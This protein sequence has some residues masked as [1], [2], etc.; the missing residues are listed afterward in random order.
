MRLVHVAST[1]LLVCLAACS[2]GGGSGAPSANSPAAG[3]TVELLAGAPAGEGNADGV[4]ATA[5]FRGPGG[6]AID[7]AGNLYVADIGNHTI[8]KITP[9]RE[10]TTFA[11]SPGSS[12]YG[13]GAGAAARFNSPRGVAIDGAGNLYVSDSGN[14][15]VRKIT[16]AGVVTGLAHVFQ[17][18]Y[19]FGPK[20]IAADSVGNVY[21][22]DPTQSVVRLVEPSGRVSTLAGAKGEPGNVDGPGATA[23]FGYPNGVAVDAAGNVFVSDST[24]HTI[25]RITPGGVV[26]TLAG[27]AGVPGNQNGAVTQATFTQPLDMAFDTAGNLYVVDLV[28]DKCCELRR[29]SPAGIVTTWPQ[30]GAMMRTFGPG[31]V[32]AERNGGGIFYSD[33]S[34]VVRRIAPGVDGEDFAGAS[35]A[36]TQLDGV[37]S[38]ARFQDARSAAVDA[39]GNIFVADA[40]L[41]RKITPAGQVTTF[42]A[43]PADAVAVDAANNLYTAYASCVYP[44]MLPTRCT[45]VLRRISPDGTVRELSASSNSDSSGTDIFRPV[46]IAVDAAGNLYIADDW[47]GAIRRLSPAGDLTTFAK[48]PSTLRDIAMDRAGNLL[49]VDGY[50]VMK[51]TSAGTVSLLAGGGPGAVDGQGS[52]AR[53]TAPTGIAVDSEGNAYVADIRDFLVRKVTPSGVVTTIAGTPG[54]QGFHPGSLPG[55]LNLPRRVAISGRNIYLP[56]GSLVAVIRNAP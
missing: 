17:F 51:V 21:V 1:T 43:V 40:G 23:R 13:D 38:N 24:Y 37:A 15:F 20:A 3:S 44:Q 29:I 49:A 5:S 8:R 33:Y 35:A 11:G 34:N 12:G 41:I 39:Q 31:G 14:Y 22:T 32:A 55:A 46:G 47:Q 26:S 50:A 18:E 7:A 52:A 19:P 45:G 16:P 30:D 54:I 28:G 4:G 42:A 25:R 36:F 6:I 2:G 48:W 27:R 9:S 10:V 53:F 56:M